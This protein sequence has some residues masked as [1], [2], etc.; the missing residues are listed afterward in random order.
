MKHW[1]VQ[2]LTALALVAATTAAFVVDGRFF[3]VSLLVI[4]LHAEQGIGSVLMDYVHSAPVRTWSSRLVQLSLL[5]T[6]AFWSY[7]AFL[8]A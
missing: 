4:V 3:L 6:L 7:H 5:L 8:L 2:R 1:V